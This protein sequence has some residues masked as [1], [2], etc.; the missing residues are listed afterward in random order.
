MSTFNGYV[1]EFPHIRIDQFRPVPGRPPPLVGFLSHVHSDHLIGLENQNYRAP[2]VY[3]SSATREL[4][5][6]LEKAFHR[7][8]FAKGLLECHRKTYEHLANI[9]RPLPLD[10]PT[11]IELS[12]GNE[13]KV[14]LLDAN[15][16]LGA[17]MFLIEDQRNSILYTGDIRAE[18]WWNGAIS[19][20]PCLVRY[21]TSGNCLD[22]IYLDTTFAT[23]SDPYRTFPS[24]AAGVKELLEKLA[25]YPHE[26][27]FYFHSWT[28][29]YEDVW[30]TLNQVLDSRIHLDEY[31]Y[32]IYTSVGKTKSHDPVVA[33]APS[34]YGFKHGNQYERGILTLDGRVRIHSCERGTGCFVFDNPDQEIIHIMPIITRHKGVDMPELG[35]GGGQGDLNQNHELLMS[36]ND[37]ATIM[38]LCLKGLTD[39]TLLDR[40]RKMLQKLSASEDKRIPLDAFDEFKLPEDGAIPLDLVPK[41]LASLAR[42]NESSCDYISM[43][44]SP[45]PRVTRSRLPKTITFPYSRHSSYGELCEFVSIFRPREL[46]PCTAPPPSEWSE[47]LS[48][49]HLFGE[50]CDLGD[51]GFSYDTDM[52]RIRAEHEKLKRKAEALESDDS[53]QLWSQAQETQRT[54]ADG[55]ETESEDE[56]HDMILPRDVRG[57]EPVP[58]D[59]QKQ[60]LQGPERTSPVT[61]ESEGRVVAQGRNPMPSTTSVRS[62]GSSST[63]KEAYEAARAGRWHEEVHLSSVYPYQ[64]SM[65]I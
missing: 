61:P 11:K 55:A 12:P 41:I 16:C 31:R 6:R 3:C 44:K 52:R 36:E 5:L 24:K 8:N 7:M 57:S 25:M 4:V 64:E 34:L 13:I 53:Q 29:G 2:F 17:V 27:L 23:K 38:E 1:K 46:Y 32:K 59:C 43:E 30:K 20:H 48:M 50:H 45:E 39:P 19:R 42:R 56:F 18:S 26:Y 60:A 37:P 58:L 22:N 10:T 28:F 47:H 65:Q 62:S 9:L 35:A 14:T 49:E 21:T 15:H 51:T 63:R 54:E 40:I 33:E